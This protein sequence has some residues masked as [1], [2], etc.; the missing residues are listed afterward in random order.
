MKAIMMGLAC[1]I[2]LGSVGCSNSQPTSTE[3]AP[4]EPATEAVAV[5]AQAAAQA[6]TESAAVVEPHSAQ[7]DMTATTAEQRA[8]Q[9]QQY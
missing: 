7:S 1:M 5:E 8:G 2:V 6:M 4:A 9:E 3:A